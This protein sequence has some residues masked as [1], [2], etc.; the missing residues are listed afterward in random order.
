MKSRRTKF[1]IDLTR[2][3]R[4][5]RTYK[6]TLYA[7]QAEAR[8]AKKLD[9]LH[10]AGEI[11]GWKGQARVPI[12]INGHKICDYVADFAVMVAPGLDE[13]HEVK[14]AETALWKLKRKLV[15]ATSP[16]L[17]LRVI[18]SRTLV[19]RSEKPRRNRGRA[20]P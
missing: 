16:S 19:E 15:A 14:G 4:M 17:K 5:K 9:L 6:G 3:G 18:D 10:L 11:L 1:G 7:S 13:L 8:Y 12:R 2:L 20:P